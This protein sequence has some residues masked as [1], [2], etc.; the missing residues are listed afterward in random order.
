MQCIKL[1]LNHRPPHCSWKAQAVSEPHRRATERGAVSLVPNG[2]L[3]PEETGTEEEDLLLPAIGDPQTG[4]AFPSRETM[5]PAG[6]VDGTSS[7]APAQVFWQFLLYLAATQTQRID[8]KFHNQ[9]HFKSSIAY[10]RPWW[11]SSGGLI[12]FL[13]MWIL[14]TCSDISYLPREI[15]IQDSLSALLNPPPQGIANHEM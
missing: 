4:T 9:L 10:P 6:A 15:K 13:L 1:A 12:W 7:D 2:L 14:I 8:V 11:N 3:K 5:L